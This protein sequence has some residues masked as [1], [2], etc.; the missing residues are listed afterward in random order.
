[1]HKATTYRTFGT[2][3]AAMNYRK[4]NGTGG[5]IFDPKDVAG[6][7]KQCILFPPSLTPSMV[8]SHVFTSGRDGKLV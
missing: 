4:D 6:E 5:W 7:H 2:A 3:S 1:M 8:F